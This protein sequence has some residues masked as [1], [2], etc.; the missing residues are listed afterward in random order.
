MKHE[1]MR[2]E[3]VVFKCLPFVEEEKSAAELYKFSSATPIRYD[4]LLGRLCQ[5]IIIFWGSI[6]IFGDQLLFF[7]DR[8]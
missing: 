6:S 4:R 1:V 3:F 7:G 8:N 5:S 2:S